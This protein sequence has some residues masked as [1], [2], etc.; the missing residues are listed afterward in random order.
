MIQKYL[1]KIF[2]TKNDRE[3]KAIQDVI[4]HINSLEGQMEALDD[5]ALQ[6]QT[7]KL[8][9]KLDQ[10]ASLDDLLPEAFAT[11]REAGKRVLGMR[12]Y[13]VQL[14]GGYFLHKG[15]ICEMRTGEGK[16]LV[17]T[18]P[19]YLNALTGKGVHVV[20][21]NDYLAIRDCEWMG[22]LYNWMGMSTGVIHTGASQTARKQAYG[23][24]ITYG[25]NNELGFDYLRDNMK[26]SLD[27]YVHRY[28]PSAHDAQAEKL[29][30]YAIIDEV[31]SV[32]IDEA[33]T[34]LIISGSAEESTAPYLRANGVMPFL[35]RDLDFTVDEKGHNVSL[36]EK[37]VDKVEARLNIGNLYAP[38]H[39]RWV[40]YIHASLKAHNLYRADKNYLV[41]E[42]KVVIIDD[43]TGRKM[44]GRRWSDG[45]HQA[46]EA[47]EGLQIQEETQTLATITFQNYFRMYEK[48]SGMTGTAETEAEEFAKVYDIDCIVVPTNKPVIRDD[49]EDL[50]YKNERGK[51]RAVIELIAE[52]HAKGQPVLVGTISV[53]KSSFL[54]HLL[55]ERGIPHHVLN[56]KQHE[57]EAEIVAQA[58]R[59]GAVTIATNMAG[60]GTDIILGGNPEL[61]AKREVFG[62]VKVQE[63]VDEEDPTY[64]EA[65]ARYQVECADQKAQVLAAGGLAIIG[66]ERHESRR[67]DNQLRG[68]AGRQGDPG[69]SQFYLSLED[70]LMRV[71]GG[72]R[73]GKIME[74]LDIPEDEPIVARSVTKAIESSQKRVEGQNF[75]ARKNLLEYDNVM[76]QQRKTIYALRRQVM[77]AVETQKLIE[78]VIDD[79]IYDAIDRYCP[80]DQRSTEWDIDALEEALYDLTGLDVDLSA[81]PLDFDQL[82]KAVTQ[83]LVAEFQDRRGRIVEAIL[84]SMDPVDPE[85]TVT[86][87]ELAEEAE[88]HWRYFER[89]TYLRAIDEHWKEHLRQMDALKEGVFLNAYAQKDPKLIYKKEG[90]DL[91]QAMIGRINTDVLHAIFHVEVKSSKELDAMKDEA[92]AR[93]EQAKQQMQ[94]THADGGLFDDGNSPAVARGENAPVKVQTL[95]RSRPKLGRNDPCWCGSGKKYKKC[96]MKED[97]ASMYAVADAEAPPPA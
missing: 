22:R 47:K 48:L 66:T 71:F 8:R 72:D 23:S 27:D 75:D 86:P 87:E 97:E 96:H 68:R 3:L 37:G 92:E 93:R 21:V 13:D 20:T 31:D 26:F 78:S 7:A 94:A 82:E 56:A 39:M 45:I 30:H 70:D 81:V 84:H 36:T 44:P 59:L 6:G 25:Q 29:L 19:G 76:N 54:S 52:C 50:V 10:G 14:T 16:T 77:A 38:E 79:S 80:Q 17:S 28:L 89:E 62:V 46:I 32:L 40:H 15:I 61:L 67:I 41:E 24:D 90:Y 11:V 9:G 51:F 33:R 60:R 1:A 53:E 49:R 57:R 55:N 91:F 5:A 63:D 2:G 4:A 73:I 18:L 12:H 35:K 74:W 64:I 43:H 58:G 85:V 42:G 69:M 65:L 34:P 95:T 88:N 83:A